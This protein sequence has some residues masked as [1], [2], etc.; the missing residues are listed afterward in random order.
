MSNAP[1]GGSL[2]FEADSDAMLHG[3]EQA[4]SLHRMETEHDNLCA[5]IKQ[6]RD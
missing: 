5:A 3:T 2:S 4:R 1:S 6:L